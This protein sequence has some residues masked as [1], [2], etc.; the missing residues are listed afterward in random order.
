MKIIG[1]NGVPEF[2][3]PHVMIA[4]K[5]KAA[6]NAPK[7]FTYNHAGNSMTV[8]RLLSTFYY[9]TLNI[10]ISANLLSLFT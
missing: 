6:A 8:D 10:Q 1:F 5:I 2:S 3:K 9:I 4:T 7:D